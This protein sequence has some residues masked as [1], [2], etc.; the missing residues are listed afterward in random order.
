M[1][2]LNNLAQRFI[3]GIVGAAAIISLMWWHPVSLALLF[4]ILAVL[5]HVE[6]LRVIRPDVQH[7]TPIHFAANL[8]TGVVIYGIIVAVAADLWPAEVLSLLLP[9]TAFL[10]I[11]ELFRRRKDPFRYIGLRLIG[12]VYIIVPFA[13]MAAIGLQNGTFKPVIPMAILFMVWTDNVFAYFTGRWLGRHKLFERISPK[14]TWEGFAGGFLFALVCGAIFHHY[15]DLFPLWQW[16]VMGALVSVTGTL[17]DLVESLLKRDLDLKD[18]SSILP[19]HGGFLDRFDA[20][21]MAVPFVYAFLAL[22]T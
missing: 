18:S 22:T 19:G 21:V 16:L 7:S 11:V 8:F 15:T 1:K 14:K 10:F 20:L 9:L 5:T 4:L 2:G 17:G 3:T 6:Y 12:L 13:L